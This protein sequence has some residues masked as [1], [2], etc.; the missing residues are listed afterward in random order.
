MKEI[1]QNLVKSWIPIRDPHTYK[2]KLGRVLCIGGNA[3]MGGAMVLMSSAALN[4]GAGLITA[5]SDP[6]NVH[7]LHARF[8][9]IMFTNMYNTE[10]LIKQIQVAKVII[11]GPGLG[12]D[13]DARKVFNTVIQHTKDDQTL[14]IDADAITLYSKYKPILHGRII[15]TPHLGEW[16]RLSGLSALE[17]TEKI[18]RQ[19]R[20]SLGATIV[21]KKARSEVYFD[22]ACWVN[23]TGNPAMATG[24]MG[25][26]LAGMIAG[27]VAQFDDFEK[28]VLSAIYLHSYIGDQ[29]ANTHY[30]TLPS[31][32]IDHISSTMRHFVK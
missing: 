15:F 4:S 28:G 10:A 8:P 23:T 5:A 20:D 19:A 13:D 31:S 18:N 3:Q 9:E 30:V 26:T 12:L 21:L 14:I 7:A 32:I 22:N 24:G 17:E 29:L 16:Q 27:F 2:N 11:V 6:I 25:D 1:T